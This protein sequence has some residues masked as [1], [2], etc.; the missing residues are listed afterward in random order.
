MCDLVM[1]LESCLPGV[2]N[3]YDDSMIPSDYNEILFNT[4]VSLDKIYLQNSDDIDLN[5]NPKKLL[6]QIEQYFET[7]KEDLPV[8]FPNSEIFNKL[9]LY[10]QEHIRY[11][12]PF[13]IL[14]FPGIIRCHANYLFKKML[15]FLEIDNP[16]VKIPNVEVSTKNNI[17]YETIP[18]LSASDKT[19]FYY[20]CFENSFTKTNNLNNSNPIKFVQIRPNQPLDKNI[21]GKIEYSKIITLE[22]K[23]REI[24]ESNKINRPFTNI[25]MITTNNLINELN[26][27]YNIILN[28]TDIMW[29]KIFCYY[30]S[31]KLILEKISD[32]LHGRTKFQDFFLTVESIKKINITLNRLY[33]TKQKLELD[34]KIIKE[35][36][37]LTDINN[38]KIITKIKDSELVGVLD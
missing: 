16:N 5:N 36:A 24:E 32:S 38:N 13:N 7:K 15:V 37:I 4:K 29:S 9:N 1:W 12:D 28:Q 18:I 19:L 3:K 35:K 10:I 2:E 23:K 26:E 20:F 22:K 14:I 31:E 11:D 25:D 33:L 27:Q 30:Q 6:Q 34:E 17:V 8:G 21:L